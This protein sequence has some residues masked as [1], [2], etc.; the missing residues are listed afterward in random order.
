MAPEAPNYGLLWRV[1]VRA[2]HLG[3]LLIALRGSGL[4]KAATLFLAVSPPCAA[5]ALLET[6]WL[7]GWRAGW[8]GVCNE[9]G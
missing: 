5:H 6:A 2:G 9:R 8:E 3:L 4:G 7:C 1:S